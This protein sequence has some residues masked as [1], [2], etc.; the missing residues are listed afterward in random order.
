[1]GS[2][3]G[4]TYSIAARGIASRQ[5]WRAAVSSRRNEI[6]GELSPAPAQTRATRSRI[7]AIILL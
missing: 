4:L 5:V 6:A 3:S 2:K 1:M 7:S